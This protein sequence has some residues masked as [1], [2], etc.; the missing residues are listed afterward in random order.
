[1]PIKPT[2]LHTQTHLPLSCQTCKMKN[3]CSAVF[4]RS[5]SD[6]RHSKCQSSLRGHYG[7]SLPS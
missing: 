1:M 7:H 6:L 5:H 3:D 4:A 2:M